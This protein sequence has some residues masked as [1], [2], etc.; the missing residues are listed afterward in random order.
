[1]LSVSITQFNP[2]L[3]PTKD[4]RVQTALLDFMSGHARRSIEQ[5][6]HP[7]MKQAPHSPKLE[8]FSSDVDSTQIRLLGEMLDFQDPT[9][10]T[11]PEFH[12]PRHELQLHGE[13]V[14]DLLTS[15]SNIDVV[16]SFMNNMRTIGFNAEPSRIKVHRTSSRGQAFML[17]FDISKIEEN[18]DVY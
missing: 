9:K 6:E 16:K 3:A 10:D 4:F 15:V 17:H 11:E 8:I 7:H 13:G 14:E 18:S 1:M 12:I 2:D 5:F